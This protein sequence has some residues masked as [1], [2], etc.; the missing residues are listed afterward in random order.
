MGIHDGHRARL[1]SEFLARPASFPDHKV[2]ELLLFYANPRA[3]TNPMAHL[4]ME[5]FGSLSGVL[6]ANPDDLRKLPGVGEHT[7]VLLKCAK[8]VSGRYL[9]ARTGL[10]DIIHGSTSAVAMLR[11]YFFGAQRELVYAIC[12]DGKKRVLGIRKVG[13]GSVNSVSI[14]NR[15]VVEAALS[16]NA[17]HLILAHN[18][19]SGLAL[20]SAED[21]L[22]TQHLCEVLALVN[23]ELLDH[24]IFADDGAVSM[25]DRGWMDP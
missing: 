2:L 4:L 17:V 9:N 8:E 6:D 10:D 11:P 25:R 13:E 14:L 3:D 7:I 15:S 21:R 12:M 24:I 20:P 1:K 5:H 23:V 22:T 16:L 18:H 19:I